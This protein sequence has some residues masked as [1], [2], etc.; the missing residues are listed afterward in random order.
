MQFVPR[1]AILTDRQIDAYT[2]SGRYGE[3]KRQDL[4]R[5][6]EKGKYRGLDA[7]IDAGE[8]GIEVQQIKARR[9]TKDREKNIEAVD[10]FVQRMLALYTS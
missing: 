10:D 8:F 9:P 2:L 4:L 1:E 5:L 6:I 7:R 3:R